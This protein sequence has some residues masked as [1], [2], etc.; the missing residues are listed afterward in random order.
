MKKKGGE[1]SAA[2]HL[3]PED[4]WGATKGV[5]GDLDNAFKG[6]AIDAEKSGQPRH[7]FYAYGSN[8]NGSTIPHGPH[9]GDETTVHEVEFPY[10]CI[11]MVDDLPTMQSNMLD[12]WADAL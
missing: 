7:A 8:L 9:K 11:R 2:P 10:R 1:A 6:C 5:A 12:I 3:G 4:I